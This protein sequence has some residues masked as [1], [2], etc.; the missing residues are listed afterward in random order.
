[1]ATSINV[2]KKSVADL[3][4]TGK[5]MPFVIPEYQ[6]PYAWSTD[7]VE[8]LFNDIWDFADTKGS[9]NGS[10]FYFLGSIV[11]FENANGEQEI[12][13][14]QQ[15]ITSLFLLL[16]AIYAKLISSDDVESDEAQNFIRKIQPAIWREDDLTGKV[17]M[18]PLK[19]MKLYRGFSITTC[20][21]LEL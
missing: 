3:L 5:D 10:E 7:E 9:K 13:D 14:G 17:N 8:T 16:R 21:I 2:S 12:I 6:R 15:R 20:S 11:S 1:M 4:A 18:R 19:H